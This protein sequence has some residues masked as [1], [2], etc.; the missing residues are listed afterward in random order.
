MQEVFDLLD[1]LSIPY[2]AYNHKPVFTIEDAEN[3]WNNIEGV[4]C[5]N[6]FLRNQKGDKHFLVI[7]EAY[8]KLSMKLL[9]IEIGFGKLSFCSPERL[10]K[11]LKLSPGSVGP[12][13]LI[14]DV[15]HQVDLYID[16]D[17]EKFE[18]INFHPNNNSCTITIKFQ[19]L[20][21]Y[22]IYTGN[23]FQFIN[24]K[25]ENI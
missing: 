22:L 13:G 2:K 18:F 25:N 7:V 21:K 8:K 23:K 6:L 9:D 5:K 11:Y 10:L 16:I 1:K 14:N 24:I 3:C 19:D 20:L 15:Q 12:F 17:L 4:L